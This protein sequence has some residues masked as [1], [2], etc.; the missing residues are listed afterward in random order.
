MTVTNTPGVLTETTA[1]LAVAPM[2]TAA[3]RIPEGDRQV[4]EQRFEGWTLLQE[5]MGTDV[6]GTT[7]G[8]VG[9]GRIGHAVAQRAYHGFDSASCTPGA[10][11]RWTAIPTVTPP[12][13]SECRINTTI[14]ATASRKHKA[15]QTPQERDRGNG[16][17]GLSAGSVSPR[18][19]A[20]SSACGSQGPG[21]GPGP[22]NSQWE[23]T[24]PP[25]SSRA[26]VR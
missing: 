3:R 18:R 2:L 24:S 19:H 7:L 20:P 13:R 8:V 1:D 9:M 17:D 23:V 25:A 11:D 14:V 21:P 26:S 5:P 4:R 15:G 10:A 12:D 6:A 16:V 22:G